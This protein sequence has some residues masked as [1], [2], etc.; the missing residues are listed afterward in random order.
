[1]DGTPPPAGLPNRIVNIAGGEQWL[2]GFYHPENESFV[3]YLPDGDTPGLEAHL[4]GGTARWFGAQRANGR[5]FMIGWA[6]PDY[7]GLPNPHNPS[8]PLPPP[9]GPG[10]EFLTRLTLLREVHYDLK[11]K[12]L[13]TNPIP[14]LTGLR[15]R[16]LASM[17]G[18]SLTPNTPYTV[19]GTEN[20]AASS[21]DVVLSF[22]GYAA[23]ASGAVFRACVLSSSSHGRGGL[24]ISISVEPASANG[25]VTSG[26]MAKVSTGVCGAHGSS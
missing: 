15:T 19:Q 12:N 4:E 13:V 20:G 18:V 11:T 26:R 23:H 21:A 8:I 6:M 16:T 9:A 1:M 3:H 10:I 5:T 7:G 25:T 22:S 17:K 24:G 2:F 14:E